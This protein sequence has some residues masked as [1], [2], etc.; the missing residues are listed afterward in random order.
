VITV[1]NS[2]VALR[3][4]FSPAARGSTV[5]PLECVR[6]NGVRRVLVAIGL[7]MMLS[8]GRACRCQGCSGL[9]SARLYVFVVL[10]TVAVCWL[11]NSFF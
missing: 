8:A 10:P 9:V 11:L 3:L 6:K 7:G 5:H 2:Q 4:R 1:T